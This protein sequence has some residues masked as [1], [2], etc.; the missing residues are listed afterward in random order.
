MWKSSTETAPTSLYGNEKFIPML[1]GF[2]SF[3][4]DFQLFL[5]RGFPSI[6]E[7]FPWIVEGFP[8]IDF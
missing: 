7:G 6:P 4:Q 1:I 8:S 3:L 5:R 2:H